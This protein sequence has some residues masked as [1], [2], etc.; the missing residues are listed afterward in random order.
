MSHGGRSLVTRT[1][2]QDG[3]CAQ[4]T[5][6]D[7]QTVQQGLSP[8]PLL[9]E[10]GRCAQAVVAV[11]EQLR[12]AE[13]EQACRILILARVAGQCVAAEVADFE[14]CARTAGLTRQTLQPYMRLAGRW[15]PAHLRYLLLERKNADG[16]NAS[17]S[18]L[19]LLARLPQ[20]RCQAWTE[21]LFQ[22]SWS[23]RQLQEAVRRE[24]DAIST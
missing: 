23:V 17:I 4:R 5:S 6:A 2:T 8:G 11:S 18:H 7:G 9:D 13:A 1:D 12:I 15:E 20:A 19:L 24:S 22:R 21:V 16:Q 10:L 14:Y 3:C